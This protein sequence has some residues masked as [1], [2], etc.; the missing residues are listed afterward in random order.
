MT[1]L[2]R[3]VELAVI[4]GLPSRFRWRG[5]RC[6]AS[7]PKSAI[8]C[9]LMRWGGLPCVWEF[10][11]KRENTNANRS[12]PR[13]SLQ[14]PPRWWLPRTVKL[15]APLITCSPFNYEGQHFNNLYFIYT[16]LPSLLHLLSSIHLSEELEC[17]RGIFG[18]R[19]TLTGRRAAVSAAGR[20]D[21]T[22]G[23]AAAAAPQ[24]L[25]CTGS[26]AA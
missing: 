26:N 22:V 8:D 20:L 24:S 25:S 12:S 5:R 14:K 7:C 9:E 4:L 15:P 11:K 19:R 1:S 21:G 16:Q 10:I 18:A 6:K 13:G 3:R 2:T 17:P 23:N